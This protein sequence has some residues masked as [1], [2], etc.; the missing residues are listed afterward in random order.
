[1]KKDTQPENAPV[2]VRILSFIVDVFFANILRTIL[3]SI[4]V[5]RQDILNC[6]KAIEQFAS[7]FPEF[8]MSEISDYHVFFFTNNKELFGGFLKVFCIFLFSGIIYNVISYLISK[9]TIG[10][11][12][13]SLR[14]KNIGDE[15]EPRM[16]K[17]MIRSFLTPLP[18]IVINCLFLGSILNMFGVHK[19]MLRDRFSLSVLAFIIRISN[20]FVAGFIAFV[21]WLFWYNLYF[22]TNRMILVD[23]VSCT[24][25]IDK[26][27]TLKLTKDTNGKTELVKEASLVVEVGDKLVSNIEKVDNILK[28]KLLQVLQFLKSKI[29][30]K[31]ENS[32]IKKN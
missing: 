28:Q 22:L 2:T 3:Q 29:I 15:N 21:F 8:K 31:K 30:K 27:F 14:V 23:F 26:N 9:K 20:P 11:K 12:L 19:V 16:Y 13:A 1:M 10:Q 17:L 7:L 6:R 18:F 24:R 5:T 4:F 32:S 25:V